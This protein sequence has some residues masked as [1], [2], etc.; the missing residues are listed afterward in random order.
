MSSRY[1][2][3]IR[4]AEAEVLKQSRVKYECPK[5][6]KKAV[7]RKANSLWECRACG[8]VVAGGAYSLSTQVGVAANKV[9]DV[10]RQAKKE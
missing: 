9:V 10:L 6:G 2:V 7:K 4:K 1:G 3:R 8:A 5:C